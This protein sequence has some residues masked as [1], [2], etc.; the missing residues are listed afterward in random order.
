MTRALDY[1]AT[2]LIDVELVPFKADP[3]QA[4]NL[5]GKMREWLVQNTI[6]GDPM[7]RDALG[8]SLKKRRVEYPLRKR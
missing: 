2:K 8:R 7:V 4:A 1:E 5:Q 6:R 3:Q